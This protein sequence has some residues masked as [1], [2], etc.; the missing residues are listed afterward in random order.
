[1]SS[2]PHIYI[3]ESIQTPQISPKSL[4]FYKEFKNLWGCQGP[5]KCKSMSAPIEKVLEGFHMHNS[6]PIDTPIKTGYT[7]SLDDFPKNDE[8]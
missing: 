7:L 3:N 8:K 6:K 4:H 1:M 5:P 2:I